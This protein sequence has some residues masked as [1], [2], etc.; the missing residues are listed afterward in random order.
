MF[1]QS[2]LLSE[3]KR[4]RVTMTANLTGLYSQAGL[5]MVI[6]YPDGRRKWIKT[7]IEIIHGQQMIGTVG[8]DEWPDW[9]PGFV[10]TKENEGSEVT[11][12][13]ARE[14]P[15]LSVF[16]I[17]CENGKEKRKVIREMTWG[18]AGDG[19]EKC[20]VGVYAAKPGNT[21]EDLV[22]NFKGLVVDK[23]EP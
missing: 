15:N 16:E 6:Y 1:Y 7:G 3:F 22:A 9:S 4:A 5:V 18:L 23:I 21:G 13:L 20:W 14:E 2:M 12:E 10:V 17:N 11:I 8:K 19:T